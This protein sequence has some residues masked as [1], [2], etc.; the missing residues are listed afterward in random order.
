MPA[1]VTIRTVPHGTPDRTVFVSLPWCTSLW[2]PPRFGG[3]L[4]PPI[5]SVALMVSAV[6]VAKQLMMNAEL[7]LLGRATLLV[8]TG[9]TTYVMV[10]LTLFRHT[11]AQLFRDLRFLAFPQRS[12][13]SD[14]EMPTS[15]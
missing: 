15:G 6:M 14:E 1:P 4:T 8:I 9:A 2:I 10:G 13:Q 3:N 5:V 7:S 11:F 12:I